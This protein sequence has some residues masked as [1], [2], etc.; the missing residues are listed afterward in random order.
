MTVT[1]FYAILSKQ[2]K[3]N[4][5]M[6]YSGQGIHEKYGWQRQGLGTEDIPHNGGA[7]WASTAG[8][9]CLEKLTR[10]GRERK[11]EESKWTAFIEAAREPQACVRD[12]SWLCGCSP[13]LPR[14]GELLGP[15]VVITFVKFFF[16]FWEKRPRVSENAIFPPL[17]RISYSFM[18]K[19]LMNSNHKTEVRLKTLL[20]AVCFRLV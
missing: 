2:T 15:H 10:A 19:I 7:F 13:V 18:P 1:L 8:K 17:D 9:T 16:I 12:C 3:R 11:G 6:C 14:D 20:Q 4:P 5:A